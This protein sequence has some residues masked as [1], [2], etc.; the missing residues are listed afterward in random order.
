MVFSII[1]FIFLKKIPRNADPHGAGT[2]DKGCVLRERDV[3]MV[4]M[5]LLIIIFIT[6]MYFI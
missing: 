3:E 2:I 4:I 6:T 5:M 1:Y